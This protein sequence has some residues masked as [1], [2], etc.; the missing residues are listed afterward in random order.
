MLYHKL[1]L[2]NKEINN[3]FLKLFLASMSIYCYITL[4]IYIDY[5]HFIKFRASQINYSKKNPNLIYWSYVIHLTNIRSLLPAFHIPLPPGRKIF[6]QY[7][8]NPAA[9][10]TACKPYILRLC[11]HQVFTFSGIFHYSFLFCRPFCKK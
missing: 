6:W 7:R 11:R 5:V 3:F 4:T 10:F 2:C 1:Y 8:K 9:S